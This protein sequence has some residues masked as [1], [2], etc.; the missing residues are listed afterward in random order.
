MCL[1]A[2]QVVSFLNRVLLDILELWQAGPQH[3]SH[4]KSVLK[5]DESDAVKECF[6]WLLP[7]CSGLS[8][9]QEVNIFWGKEEGLG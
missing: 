9:V 2:L 1:Q 7:L 6:V 4:L 5:R 8:S 3:C